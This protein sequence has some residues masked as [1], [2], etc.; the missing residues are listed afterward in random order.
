MVL[1]QTLQNLADGD[2][3]PDFVKPSFI[4]AWHRFGNV[5]K[6]L[7]FDIDAFI[8]ELA[9]YEYYYKIV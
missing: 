9:D 6:I 7:G 8:K 3:G 2:D 1:S 5:C 4:F